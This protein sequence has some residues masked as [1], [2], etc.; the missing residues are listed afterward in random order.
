MAAR[1][2]PCSSTVSTSASLS[3]TLRFQQHRL[4]ASSMYTVPKLDDFSP[5]ALDAAARELKSALDSE[6]AAVSGESDSKVL[7]DRWIA[8][9]NGILT[10]LNDHWLKAAPGSAKREV[11]QRVNE[12]KKIV[13]EQLDASLAR[14]TSSV[15]AS[16]LQQE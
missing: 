7:R 2:R 16:R 13:E 12:L 6:I 1:P 4:K 10:Q 15:S 3:S 11:G 5:A 14:I 9:K 8:R